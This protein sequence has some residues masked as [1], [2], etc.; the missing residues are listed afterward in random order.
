MT[1][2]ALLLVLVPVAASAGT[3]YHAR[4]IRPSSAYLEAAAPGEP[5]SAAHTQGTVVVSDGAATMEVD[6]T[7]GA[8]VARQPFPCAVLHRLSGALVGSCGGDVVAFG[9]QLSVAWRAHWP[10]PSAL[11]AKD[12]FANGSLIVA[13]FS[14][15]F[16]LVLR[17]ATRAGAVVSEV[18]TGAPV[19]DPRARIDVDSH[20]TTIVAQVSY[21]ASPTSTLVTLTPD[22]RRVA[23]RRV[24]PGGVGPMTTAATRDAIDPAEV[25]GLGGTGVRNE[26][27]LGPN[28]FWY[29]FGCCGAHP[30]LFVAK[31]R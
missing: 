19:P 10:T 21:W 20:G 28:H 23:A 8:V 13:A 31:V 3:R 22:G 5:A 12:M 6:V 18:R 25:D 29:T 1:K 30:G 15:S 17:I 4:E 26:F 2:L 7:S 24:F 11:V 16:E 9:P 27:D 14:E